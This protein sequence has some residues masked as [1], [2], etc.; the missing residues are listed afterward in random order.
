ML[1]GIYDLHKHNEESFLHE[2]VIHL[3]FTDSI[4]QYMVS[5]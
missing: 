3:Y 4:K 1:T 5:R 2:S